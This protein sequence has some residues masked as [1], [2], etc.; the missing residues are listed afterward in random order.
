MSTEKRKHSGDKVAEG[1]NDP[2]S[3]SPQKKSRE[4]SIFEVDEKGKRIKP[5]VV[6]DGTYKSTSA[7]SQPFRLHVN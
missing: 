3:A 6:R 2:H 5:V 1:T 4:S 7:S